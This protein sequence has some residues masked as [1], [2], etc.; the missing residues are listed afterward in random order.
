MKT[1]DTKEFAE[2]TV[3]YSTKVKKA[4]R[5]TIKGAEDCEKV[6]RAIYDFNG[7]IEHKESFYTMYLNQANEVIGVT[8][9][10]EG[11]IDASVVDPILIFQ[12]AVLVGAKGIILCHNHPSGNLKQSAND[13]RMTEKIKQGCKLLD[14]RLLDHILI[15]AESYKSFAN[16]GILTF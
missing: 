11:G 6:F 5:V 2:V 16:E 1:Y 3:H 15:T 9:I 12:S 13:E 14:I 10:S 7:N 8:K 4:D